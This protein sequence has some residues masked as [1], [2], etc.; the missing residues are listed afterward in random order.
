MTNLSN[1]IF[2]DEDAAR[3]YLEAQRWPDGPW[4]PHCGETEKIKK[5]KG[6]SHRPGLHQCNSCRGHFTVTVGTVYER[7]KI[8]LHKWLM[9]THLICASKK[10]ISSHQLHRML[11]VTYKTAWFMAHR[12]RESMRD[13][14]PGPL[15]GEGQV[16][17]VDEMFW[18]NV[19]GKWRFVNRRGWVRTRPGSGFHHKEKIL[20]LVERGGR[21]RSFHIKDVK[22]KTLRQIMTKEISRKS[23]LMTDHAQHYKAIGREFS[24]HESVDHSI[25]EYVRGDVSTNTIEGY[26]SILKRGL[27]GVYQH[28]SEQHLIRY[29]TEF[30]FRYSTREIDDAARAR[31]ALKGIEGKRLTYG[32]PHSSL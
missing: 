26:F 31:L 5:L 12:I 20:T 1:P 30:D 18:G 21:A 22:A 4:C 25:G 6:K 27:T 28:V 19:K 8:P 10:G 23:R 11:G 16:V 24:T 17:E 3:S 14:K 15:G 7:S 13:V 2:H 29:V 9:A 32:G